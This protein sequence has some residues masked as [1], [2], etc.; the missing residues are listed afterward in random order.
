MGKNVNTRD[1]VQ[2]RNTPQQQFTNHTK[3]RKKSTPK[4]ATPIPHRSRQ[5][6]QPR[7][8]ILVLAHH[9]SRNTTNDRQL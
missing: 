5:S 4:T 3:N 8:A 2:G 9:E 6:I 7:K 1:R